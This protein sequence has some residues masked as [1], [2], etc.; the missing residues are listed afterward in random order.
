MEYN[1]IF[2]GLGNPGR[3]YHGTR[4]NIG[5]AMLDALLATAQEYGRVEPLS[6]NKFHCEL[7]RCSLPIKQG[8]WLAAKPQTYMNLSGQSVQPLLAWHKLAPKDLMVFHDELDIALGQ[9]RFKSGGGNAGHNGLKSL[10]QHLGSPDFHRVR[11]GI[12]RPPQHE[13]GQDITAWVLGHPSSEE[14]TIQERCFPD[15]LRLI[16]IFYK[17]GTKAAAAFALA[18]R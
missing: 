16:E 11:I 4:H 8:W 2:V 3:Q 13:H 5:F 18:V 1:G 7:W 14:K 6:G 12:G 10:T 15:I 17:E 9:L